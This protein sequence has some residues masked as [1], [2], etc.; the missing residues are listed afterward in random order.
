MTQRR[1]SKRTSAVKKRRL[2]E[3]KLKK[4]REAAD[5]RLLK[6][7]S[8][9]LR[10]LYSEEFDSFTEE[11]FRLGEIV[12]S[13]NSSH[14]EPNSDC[15]ENSEDQS[16][17]SLEWDNSGE[18]SPSFLTNR[19]SPLPDRRQSDVSDIIDSILNLDDSADCQ[20]DPPVPALIESGNSA[21][22]NTSTDQQFLDQENPV[23]LEPKLPTNYNWPPKF[24]SQEPDHF[25]PFDSSSLNQDLISQEDQEVFETENPEP[26]SKMEEEDFK[27]RNRAI[28]IAEAKV[29]DTKKKFLAEN[30]TDLDVSNYVD[31]LEKIRNKL[32]DFEDIVND[33]I[34]DLDEADATDKARITTL[35]AAKDTLLQEVL[36]NETNVKEKVK[37][38][39]S[40]QPITKA[41]Q[42]ALDLKKKQHERYEEEKRIAKVEK[43]L[44][45]EID[46]EDVTARAKSLIETLHSVVT[47]KD[48]TDLQ[49]REY[50]AESRK[51]ESKLED[52]TASK[53]KIDKDVVGLDIST[54]NKDKLSEVVNKAKQ[55]CLDAISD[56]KKVD[57]ERGL[58]SLSKT[59]KEV[60]VYPPPFSGKKGEDVYKFKEKFVEAI[61]A[62]QIRE[63][64]KVEVLRKHL[65]DNA[66]TRVGDHYTSFDKAISE[67]VE[68]FGQAQNTWDVK[69]ENFLKSC[70]DSSL[71]VKLG[72]EK[73]S[74][75]IGQ[76]CEF[77]REA[78]KLAKDHPELE[79]AIYGPVT[80]RK[81]ISVLP[82]EMAVDIVKAG[83]GH[84]VTSKQ[85]LQEIQ[86]F[87]E[88]EHSYAVELSQW[89]DELSQSQVNFASVNAF[90]TKNK[91]HKERNED[92]DGHDCYKSASCKTAWGLLG[93][94]NLYHLATV[95]ERIEMFKSKF[96]CFFCGRKR[97]I[98]SHDQSKNKRGWI[99]KPNNVTA[100]SPAVCKE[101]DC[102]IG[103]ALCSK[104]PCT[105]A[106]QELLDWIKK[107]QLKTTVTT[108]MTSPASLANL[109]STALLP[110]EQ[111]KFSKA[112]R[113]K[114]QAGDMCVPFSNDQLKDFFVKD[115]KSKGYHATKNNVLPVPEGE[116]AFVF[117]KIKGRHSGIQAF[118][119]S[120][121]NC[122]IMS[123]GIPQRELNSCKLQDGP[124]SIDVATGL[125]VHASGEW[126]SALPL[127]DG[128][129]Q[130]LRGLTVPRVTSDM[131][132]MRLDPW[133]EKVKAIESENKQLQ[134]ISIPKELGGHV[135]M[136]LG[137]SFS[138]VHPEP[139]HTFPDGLTIYKSKFLPMNPGELACI[140]GP[141]ASIEHM[142]QHAGAR[143]TIRHLCNFL[144]N[145]SAGYSPRLEFFPSSIPEMERTFDNFADKGIPFF[146]GYLDAE[147]DSPDESTD[148]SEY[149]SEE[150]NQDEAV[151][152]DHEENDVPGVV[153]D[154]C[155]DLVLCSYQSQTVKFC[156]TC[157]YDYYDYFASAYIINMHMPL[158][159]LFPVISKLVYAY[160]M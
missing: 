104:H 26:S 90:D 84:K 123:D 76:T 58:F 87:L 21:R 122:C 37:Q 143:S 86:T 83:S 157:A 96:C 61:T 68:I 100:C 95:D 92:R 88:K 94:V 99:C 133:F 149:D 14:P 85:K 6:S 13:L 93:C 48:L 64:D 50:L 62:N 140:G 40:S 20:E 75:A 155:G 131:P 34:A 4:R 63:K 39:M 49:V 3:E 57:S 30:V 59:I 41:E 18:T 81:V 91:K 138:L 53:L 9:A 79:S 141:M 129:H 145:V 105:N 136:I 16:F 118:I 121:A 102:N 77:L 116:I 147:N 120:G 82:P 74:T 144:S 67:L 65:R 89:S 25:D 1:L 124:I 101:Q 36:L 32:E 22:R 35:D 125:V 126:G 150:E 44:K 113:S 142:V 151:N 47:T 108:L 8:K 7:R 27:L 28:K 70:K 109:T 152:D 111:L 11:A 66:K 52:I 153:C 127:S 128:S 46:M 73:R 135:D 158:R 114:L 148:D 17:K 78:D 98:G 159:Y 10:N 115:L 31:R 146:D 45:A 112:E 154:E 42:E 119:D 5:F 106:K 24:P 110:P 97:K 137:I 55:A 54:E 156:Q 15:S 29:K 51:W 107:N 117:C 23:S 160:T 43:K 19:T 80:V 12:D 72:S 134:E 33:L 2:L 130:L 69:V 60:A 38:L 56:L 71:W 132:R 139:I 103:A